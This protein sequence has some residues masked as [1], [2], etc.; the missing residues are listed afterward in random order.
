MVDFVWV[1]G[2]CTEVEALVG[3]NL[4]VEVGDFRWCC[5]GELGGLGEVV[6]FAFEVA[7]AWAGAVDL[8]LIP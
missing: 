2:P 1:M 6:P 7:W 4:L 8:D 5:V 3:R